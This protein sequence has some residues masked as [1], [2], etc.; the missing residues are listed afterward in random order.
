[1]ENSF[2][3]QEEIDALLSS[4]DDDAS[5][6]ENEEHDSKQIQVEFRSEG[7]LTPEEMDALGEIGNISAGS[8]STALSDFLN[9]KVLINTPRVRIIT[10]R[11][12][13]ESFVVPYIVIE[14]NYTSGIEGT[15]LLVIKQAD[16]AIIADLMMGGDGKNVDPILDDMKMSAV[17]EAV[18]QMVGSSATSMSTIFN[19]MVA[20]SPPTVTSM[21]FDKESL[22]VFGDDEEYI[23]VISFNLQIG[24][25]IDSDI[26]QIIP[27][28]IARQE[29]KLLMSGSEESVDNEEES[30]N[31]D[32]E[33]NIEL[34]QEPGQDEF[35]EASLISELTATAKKNYNNNL[36]LI[37]DIPL[38]ISVL[39]GKTQKPINEILSL[40][41]GSII[42][43][44][45]LADEP[46]DILVNGTLI[47]KGEVVVISENFGVKITEIISRKSRI[48]KLG[49]AN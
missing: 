3:S 16:A 20:I 25:L 49:E 29:V 47:A 39:L 34:D 37:L 44:Q 10:Q 36:E 24:E 14:I 26:I 46:V 32:R 30:I 6:L 18:N 40:N 48:K 43:L 42:E 4:N 22:C 12:L 17:S 13:Y 33:K 31:V 23:A 45:R 41:S 35:T 28:D 5:G 7:L 15:N 9:Q 1:M 8:A 2:L 38:K 19:K 11:E 27:V 21:D